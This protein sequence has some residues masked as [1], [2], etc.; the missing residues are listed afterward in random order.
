MAALL[1]SITIP[2]AF[3]GTPSAVLPRPTFRPSLPISV[4]PPSPQAA[5]EEPEVCDLERVMRIEHGTAK[6]IA[7]GVGFDAYGLADSAGWMRPQ[8][9]L[10]DRD[11]GVVTV[12]FVACAPDDAMDA[13]TPVESHI[14]L[15]LDPD[16]RRV[17]IR[18]RTN[19]VSINVGP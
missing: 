4:A 14:A 13:V 10:A 15:G 8:L 3:A 7:G 9:V 6:A 17:I 2:A 19:T 18:S 1:V 5:D 12:D 11:G 16:V